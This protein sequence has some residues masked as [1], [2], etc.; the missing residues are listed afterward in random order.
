MLKKNPEI[1][2]LPF[3]IFIFKWIISYYYFT[4]EN[5]E[6]KVINESIKDGYYYFPFIKYFSELTL[7]PSFDLTDTNLK[8]IPLPFGSLFVHVILFKLLNNISFAIILGELFFQVSFFIIVYLIFLKILNHKESV[9]VT[10]LFFSIPGILDITMMN[11]FNFLNIIESNLY[12]TRFPRP[13]VTNVYLYLSIF[14]L[15]KY[16]NK[17]LYKNYVSALIGFVV[18][19]LFSSFYFYFVI[20]SLI[21]FFIILLNL[22]N[23]KN[24]KNILFFILGF[25]PGI[26]FFYNATFLSEP[27][28]MLR[29]GVMELNIDEKKL[30]LK[31]YLSIF[32]NIKFIAVF[33]LISTIFIFFYKFNKNTIEVKNFFSVFYLFFISTILS[34]IIFVFFSPKLN[35]IYHFN[36]LIIISI[37]IFFFISSVKLLI[38]KI[39]LNNYSYCLFIFLLIF[40]NFFIIFKKYNKIDHNR[41]EVNH[42]INHLNKETLK[43]KRVLTL[44]P[45]LMVWFILNDF[46]YINLLNGNFYSLKDDAIELNLINNLKF[47]NFDEK[48]FVNFISNK[49]YGWRYINF[50]IQ[51]FFFLKYQANSLKTFNNSD[52]FDKEILADIKKSSPFKT[53]QIIIPNFELKRLEKKFLLSNNENFNEPELVVINLNKINRKKLKLNNFCIELESKNYIIYKKCK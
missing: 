9:L 45:K 16:Y 50:N 26:I 47:L 28:F 48:D 6:I 23:T 43:Q 39:N 18:S 3:L 36:N 29:M 10:F 7:N 44:E 53:Q 49:K 37:F 19:L 14:L 33:F 34:P 20:I 5:L 42:I 24:K 27:D 40:L 46:K 13:L 21:I 11:N 2:I 22:K 30:L 51:Q 35:V 12:N 25:F 4:S 1:I 8:N 41:E 31:K 15:I 38:S 52:D 32:L 17:F